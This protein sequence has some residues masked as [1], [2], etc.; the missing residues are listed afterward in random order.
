MI[1]KRDIRSS[2]RFEQTP[3]RGFAASKGL[4]KERAIGYNPGLAAPE[5]RRTHLFASRGSL[6]EERAERAGH[7][8][9][10]LQ[11]ARWGRP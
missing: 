11:I 5:K 4:F 1:Q 6:L 9:P 2:Y 3:Q 8:F 7:F 10:V